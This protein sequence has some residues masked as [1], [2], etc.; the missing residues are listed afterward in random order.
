VLPV[1]AFRDERCVLPN[2]YRGGVIEAVPWRSSVADG[3]ARTFPVDAFQSVSC[4]GRCATA[5]KSVTVEAVWRWC[6]GV[7]S[8]F[9]RERAQAGHFYQP[10][11]GWAL[12]HGDGE[13]RF[14]SIT[15]TR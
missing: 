12:W 6:A 4:A 9:S 15:R 2:E 5:D 3:T 14:C 13:R 1:N 10:T 7:P 8:P 11:E